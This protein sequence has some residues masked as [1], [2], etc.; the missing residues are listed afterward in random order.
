MREPGACGC[1]RA[2][3]ILQITVQ[4]TPRDGRSYE[5]TVPLYLDGDLSKPYVMIEVVGAG[6]HPRLTFDVRECL[7]PPV[8]E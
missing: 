2:G 4:F 1:A 3:E 5:T 8:S 7:L 6:Q